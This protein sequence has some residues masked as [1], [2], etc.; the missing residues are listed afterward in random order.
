MHNLSLVSVA[1]VAVASAAPAVA[2]VHNHSRRAAEAAFGAVE[3]PSTR[4]DGPN[5]Y[6]ITTTWGGYADDGQVRIQ[7]C[8]GGKGGGS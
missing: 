4:P 8:E 3:G 1:L 5:G 2:P 7:D 6:W